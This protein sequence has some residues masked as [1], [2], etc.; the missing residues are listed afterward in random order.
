[1]EENVGL[2]SSPVCNETRNNYICD[3]TNN[4]DGFWHKE[5]KGKSQTL[6]RKETMF[7]YIYPVVKKLL[8]SNMEEQKGQPCIVSSSV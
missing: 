6:Q 5:K 4:A 8:T 3:F 1:M 7:S 2:C